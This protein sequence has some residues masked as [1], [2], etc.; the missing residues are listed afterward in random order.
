MRRFLKELVAASREK[1]GPWLDEA[2]ALR[3]VA[4]DIAR[5][6]ADRLRDLRQEK[7]SAPDAM[8]TILNQLVLELAYNLIEAKKSVAVA[9]ADRNR[10]AKYIEQE[11]ANVGEWARRANEAAR[12]GDGALAAEALRRRAEHEALLASLT[13]LDRE[14]TANVELLKA[15]LRELNTRIEEAKRTKNVILARRHVARTREVT[16]IEI[17]RVDEILRLV[18]RLTTL[19]E[20]PEPGEGEGGGDDRG[21]LN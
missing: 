13:P 3:T 8:E 4:D 19:E 20:P 18:D 17:R 10:L 1:A 11:H 14:Q 12:A 5:Y 6:A 2:R 7:R 15:T 16:R 21:L 9:I